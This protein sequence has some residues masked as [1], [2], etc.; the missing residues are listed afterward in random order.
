MKHHRSEVVSTCLFL[1][2][3]NP[4]RCIWSLL[5]QEICKQKAAC[6]YIILQ[7]NSIEF[8][9]LFKSTTKAMPDMNSICSCSINFE[10]SQVSSLLYLCYYCVVY[11][12]YKKGGMKNYMIGLMH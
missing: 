4:Y 8:T 5:I 9:L 11:R 3:N 7:T 10:E 1:Q 12:K 2:Y 6:S